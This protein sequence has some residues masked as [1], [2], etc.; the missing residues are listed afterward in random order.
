VVRETVDDEYEIPAGFILVDINEKNFRNYVS[1]I[2]HL[3]TD[4]ISGKMAEN[5]V[6]FIKFDP[7]Y[8]VPEEEVGTD[9][10]HTVL[11]ALSCLDSKYQ[12]CPDLIHPQHGYQAYGCCSSSQYGCC[13]DNITPAPAPFFDVT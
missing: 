8:T 2:N 3:I 12:C 13:P 6:G 5:L 9:L 1:R 4:E 10:Q 7:D 11:T